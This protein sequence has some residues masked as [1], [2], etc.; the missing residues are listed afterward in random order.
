MRYLTGE[1]C[2]SSVCIPGSGY[3]LVKD[4]YMYQLYTRKRYTPVNEEIL[5]LKTLLYTEKTIFPFTKLI[6]SIR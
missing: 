6:P 5:V 3:M 1:K 2:S 4:I